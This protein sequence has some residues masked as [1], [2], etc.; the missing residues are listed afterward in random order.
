MVRTAS[1]E[2]GATTSAAFSLRL[3][4]VK[5]SVT[6]DDASPQIRYDSHSVGG[7]IT[8]SEIQNLPL[9]G[10]SFL[11]LAKLEP[12]VQPPARTSGNRTMVP[13]PGRREVP[14]EAEPRYC[15]RGSVMTVGLFERRHELLTGRGAGVPDFHRQLR[16]VHR[17]HLQRNQRRHTFRNQR[18]TWLRVLFLPRSQT[19]GLPRPEARSG[20]PGSI[21]PAPPVR[22]RGRRN[23]TRPAVLLHNWERS[24]NESP[25]RLCLG[26]LYGLSR[27]TT[28]PLFGNH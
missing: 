25:P 1:V 23:H 12:G 19:V 14:T 5:E 6:V 18:S 28:T 7:V 15:D 20:Q 10:R 4:D 9:N 3:G 21:L 26:G 17:A 2:A 13:G 8:G 16:P 11:E 27:T 24:D 22:F